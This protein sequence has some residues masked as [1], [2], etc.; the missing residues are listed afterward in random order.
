MSIPTYFFLALG[1]VCTTISAQT[2]NS[3]AGKEGYAINANN[4]SIVNIKISKDDG[5]ARQLES[6][7]KSREEEIR[8]KN[9]KI[10]WLQLNPIK[11]ILENSNKNLYATLP[12]NIKKLQADG[13]PQSAVDWLINQANES[14]NAAQSLNTTAGQ[15]FFDAAT[16]TIETNQLQSIENLAKAIESNPDNLQYHVVL[17]TLISRNASEYENH[18]SWQRVEEII[19]KRYDYLDKPLVGLF[20]L[21]LAN[22]QMQEGQLSMA[23]ETV[24]RARSLTN[25]EILKRPTESLQS[26]SILLDVFEELIDLLSSDPDDSQAFLKILK[27]AENHPAN[28]CQGCYTAIAALATLKILAADVEIDQGRLQ[29]ATQLLIN[30]KNSVN[31]LMVHLQPEL[32]QSTILELLQFTEAKLDKA[33]DLLGE[34]S[35]K[36][37]AVI[38]STLKK[39]EKGHSTENLDMLL[40]AIDQK[41]QILTLQNQPS[42]KSEDLAN[43][44]EMQVEAWRKGKNTPTQ[45][46][47]ELLYKLSNIYSSAG[48]LEKHF[49][50]LKDAEEVL[51]TSTSA[52]N[53]K[54]YYIQKKIR[55]ALID[56]PQ[57]IV[58]TDEARV[59]FS[60]WEKNLNQ[61]LAKNIWKSSRFLEEADLLTARANFIG[62]NESCSAAAKLADEAEKLLMEFSA[63]SPNSSDYFATF[64][65]DRNFLIKSKC[66]KTGPKKLKIIEDRFNLQSKNYIANNSLQTADHK[67]WQVATDF[68]GELLLNQKQDLIEGHTKRLIEYAKLCKSRSWDAGS[69]SIQRGIM[70]A[71]LGMLKDYNSSERN[72]LLSKSYEQFRSAV[73][74]AD[75]HDLKVISNTARSTYISMLTVDAASKFKN[76]EIESSKKIY[77]E[78]LALY[79]ALDKSFLTESMRNWQRDLYSWIE[80]NNE[81][82][83]SEEPWTYYGTLEF[84]RP[85]K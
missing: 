29:N 35:E 15:Y 7:L 1:I 46:S 39:L 40:Q 66:L 9:T 60:E 73:S 45:S 21:L 10:E 42:K 23:R 43:I 16:L 55:S 5:R 80:S 71:W 85:K 31:T 82:P 75:S 59:I 8:E 11:T 58:S 52:V 18:P 44:A 81:N 19:R 28:S 36:T 48:K 63:R 76:K 57:K 79:E 13:N 50:I 67:I 27:N 4:G 51:K 20:Y 61:I 65:I 84:F 47:A 38:T 12:E 14:R 72:E 2:Q 6:Q 74:E 17:L 49:Q 25:T 78:C 34:A 33:N 70:F 32:T 64:R 83:F 54:D 26:I 22:R 37:D 56:A 68:F 24:S 69:C 3:I 62:A 77:R 30:A 41:V 53:P